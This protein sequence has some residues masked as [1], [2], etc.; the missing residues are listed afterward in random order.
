MNSVESGAFSDVE[1]ATKEVSSCLAE[2]VVQFLWNL[3]RR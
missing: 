1:K 3:D 2:V